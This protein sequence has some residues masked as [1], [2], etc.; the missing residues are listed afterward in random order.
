MPSIYRPTW[1]NLGT[2]LGTASERVLVC[3]PYIT[4]SGINRLFDA[5][6]DHVELELITRLSPSDWASRVSDPEAMM[7]LLELWRDEGNP[8]RLRVVQ[9][10]HAKLYAADDSRVLVGSSNLSEGGFGHNVELMVELSGDLA[11]DAVCAL[12]AAC[13]PHFRELSIEQLQ[14]WI[15]HSREAVFAVRGGTTAE[16]PEALADVQADLDQMLGFGTSSS[17]PSMATVPDIRRFIAW[18]EVTSGLSGAK[19]IL[20]RHRN[21][22]GQNLTG[23]VKQ[24]FFGCVRFFRENPKF[25]AATSEALEELSADDLY[26]I[27][28]AELESAWMAHLNEH[29]LDVGESYSYPT[30]RGILPP[31]LGG[32]RQG[33]GGGMS[34]LKRLLP[35][36]A[37]WVHEGHNAA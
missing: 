8:T 26:Q 29:A 33:G 24:C 27:T 3:S 2:A 25:V 34:T 31:S 14:E 1:D 4:N 7:T 37:R 21:A 20:R 35:L 16:E 28:D 22:D 19:I 15:D 10:L 30:L 17:P 5:L 11:R 36:V 23:H 6:P 18:V 32:T 13:A 12:Q 9:P